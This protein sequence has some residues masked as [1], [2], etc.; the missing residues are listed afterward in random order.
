MMTAA[1]VSEPF[2]T[3][4]EVEMEQWLRLRFRTLCITYLTIDVVL[5]VGLLLTG[6]LMSFAD[7]TLGT[8]VKLLTWGAQVGLVIVFLRSP[9]PG[10]LDRAGLLRLTTRMV[11]WLGCLAVLE[12]VMLRLL[13]EETLEVVYVELFFLHVTTCLL[14]PWRPLESVRPF[15]ALLITMALIILIL[16]RQAGWIARIVLI[17]VSPTILVPG[18]L[19]CLWR[20]KRHSVTFQ[21]RMLGQH[22]TT[23]RQEMYRARTIHESMF[24]NP[25]ADEFVRFEYKYRPM[26]E[27]GGDFIHLTVSPQGILYGTLLDVT[28][29]GLPAALTV[30]RLYGEL[31]RLRAEDP[32]IQPDV[33]LALLNRYVHLTMQRHNIYVTAISVTIDPFIGHVQYANAGHPPG[34]LRDA[35]GNVLDLGSTGALL[36]ALSP[37]EYEIELR[38][39][40]LSPGDVVVLYTDGAFEAKNREGTMLGLHTLRTMLAHQPPP[41]SWPTFLDANVA[42][43]HAGLSDDDVLIAAFTF[44]GSRSARKTPPSKP[45][46]EP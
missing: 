32:D 31:E 7:T 42:N 35:G 15:T 39:V 46:I 40:A 10:R 26:R 22:F 6:D 17:I 43:H 4:Y 30:N 21:R 1:P 41:A 27:L 38:D 12:T 24:P 20:L 5:L 13:Q 44:L 3:E 14:L 34:F 25:Y 19:I 33:L 36:G 11:F 45:T 9:L 28:G 16:P 18:L 23:M 29:H 2:S 37:D 8:L